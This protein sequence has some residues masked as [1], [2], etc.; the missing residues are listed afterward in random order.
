VLKYCNNFGSSE[1]EGRGSVGDAAAE[2]ARPAATRA[3][4]VG[5][6]HNMKKK[7]KLD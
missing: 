4:R 3:E 6:R 5:I 2:M 1:Q 7:D